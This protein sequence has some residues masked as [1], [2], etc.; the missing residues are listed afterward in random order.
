[1]SWE[2]RIITEQELAPYL[3]SRDS[4]LSLRVGALL[5]HQRQHWQ[6]LR[7]GYD[8]FQAMET[9]RLKVAEAEVVVQHNPRRIRSS[10][11]QVDKESISTRPC[12][13][14]AENLPPEER[15]LAFGDFVILCNPF[16]VLDKH[17]SI[18]DRNHGEQSIAGNVG[19]LLALARELGS[20]Y[21]VLY[22]GPEC[23]ASAPDH[24]HF[25][26]CSNALLPVAEHLFDSEPVLSEECSSCEETAA[27]TFELFSLGGSGRTNV[28][29]RGG[30]LR[31][32]EQWLNRFIDEFGKQTEKRE[33]MLNIISAYANRIWTV[34]VFP[35]ARH[36]PASFYEQ[37]PGRLL[38]SPGAIDMAGVL[39]VP[40]REH[41]DRLNGELIERIYNEVSYSEEIINNLLDWL[42]SAQETF[43]RG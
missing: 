31:E 21:F 30:N 42:T 23:G 1:V 15:A 35:R 12:F 28:V 40:E 38:V 6:L 37:G 39:V 22:N 4:S 8:A 29:F 18:V 2:A 32:L 25:Q 43:F 17:L 14:C 3:R 10:A 13:L 41:Y 7:E 19:S 26:A 20:Q 16:P 5:E 36:R 34:F 33:P 9:K 24:L 11:A 27:N